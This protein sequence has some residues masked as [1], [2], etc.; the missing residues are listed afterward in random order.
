MKSQQLHLYSI[1]P[2]DTDH[3]DEICEDIRRQY[4]DGVATCALFSMTLVP[5]GNPPVDKAALLCQKYDR[6]REKLTNMG[7]GSGVLVQATIGHG[8]A[9]SERFPYQGYENLVDGAQ[10]NTV[11]PADEGFRTYIRNAMTTIAAHKPD[12][13]MVDDDFRLLFRQGGGCACPL[14]LERFARLSGRSVTRKELLNTVR[15][16]A[17][18]AQQWSD[19]FVQTQK[20]SLLECAK[21]IRAGID[22]ID[23]TLPG[24]FCCVGNSVEFAP[25]IAKI[26]AGKGNPVVIRI[27][28]ANYTPFGAKEFSRSFLKAASQFAKL[29]GHADI[30]LAE[31]D[32]CPQNRYSTG[33]RSLH[34]HFTGSVLEGA[35]GAKH[36]I[37]RLSAYEPES[38]TAY[39]KIL[40]KHRGFYQAL[41]DLVPTLRWRGF[42][43][44]VCD[45]PS[46]SIG[47]SWTQSRDGTDA[48]SRCV[49]ERFGLPLYFSAENGGV[50][51]MEGDTDSCFNDAQM[52]DMLRGNMMLASD[53]AKN[54]IDRGFGRYLGANVREW[55]GKQPTH[56]ILSV[57]GNACK[58]QMQI[59]ELIPTSE[60]TREDSTVYHSVDGVQFERLFPGST[61]FQ[62]ELGGQIFLFSGTPK[63][64]FDITEAFSFLNL[65]RKQ[66]LIRI[67]KEAN[68]L[69]VYYPSDED[70][71]FRAADMEDGS[72]FCALFNLSSDPIEETQL[73]CNRTIRSIER[74]MPSGEWQ[75]QSF[76][77]DDTHTYTVDVRCEHLDPIVLRL[78]ESLSESK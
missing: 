51:C 17:P 57:N 36:W 48:W 45:T 37:T 23:P 24:S 21:E 76:R 28:N 70:V 19:W 49:L 39:R 72:L 68:E 6:F 40:A 58:I 29:K 73:I 10:T 52:T 35:N 14:H 61:V 13:I 64:R 60:Q 4:E 78:S 26:L 77:S 12:C 69:P 7:I 16:D 38:G 63:A 41:A 46:F 54:L 74:L 44:P 15:G 66:Q 20:D 56:E 47:E 50:V 53:S 31:T 25:D 30:V 3:L 27:N 43:I 11:C 5:E 67:L 22:A 75:P 32:T 65:S 71:Y 9:L 34:T 42:R 18:H 33:A 2:L 8:W 1:M 62:N 55:A 59:R